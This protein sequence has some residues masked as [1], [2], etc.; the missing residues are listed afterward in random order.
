MKAHKN[1]LMP[2]GTRQVPTEISQTQI[3]EIIQNPIIK[4]FKYSRK[5][6]E[7]KSRGI[8]VGFL[9]EFLSHIGI[10]NKT[11]IE[12]EEYIEIEK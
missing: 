5:T 6:V 11:R 7:E 12:K 4:K 2:L 8:G 10:K 9:S 3:K 1:Q